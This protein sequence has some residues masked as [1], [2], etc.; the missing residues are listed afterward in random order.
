M[1]DSRQKTNGN[2]FE[3]RDKPERRSRP[4]RPCHLNPA[5]KNFGPF[6][7]IFADGRQPQTSPAVAENLYIVFAPAGI[8]F[9]FPAL[10]IQA[11]E[12]LA[13]KLH[14]IAAAAMDKRANFGRLGSRLGE[15]RLLATL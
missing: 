1:L 15:C 7:Q 14:S 13:Q 8:G 6:K 12:K 3:C 4:E 5:A 9:I 11:F 10:G 2:Q